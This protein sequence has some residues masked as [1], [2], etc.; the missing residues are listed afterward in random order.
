M[1]VSLRNVHKKIQINAIQILGE[2]IYFQIRNTRKY[3]CG[4][5]VILNTMFHRSLDTD[6]RHRS[7]DTVLTSLKQQ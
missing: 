1:S 6:F 3:F 2:R 5:T 7:L 4:D